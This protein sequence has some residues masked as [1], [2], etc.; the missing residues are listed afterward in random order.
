M[1]SLVAVF[2]FLL[3]IVNLFIR[4]KTELKKRFDHK[5]QINNSTYY[6]MFSSKDTDEVF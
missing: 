5:Y 6:E 1:L 2:F 4:K 3:F